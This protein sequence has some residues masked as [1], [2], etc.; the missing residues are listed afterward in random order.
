MFTIS[1]PFFDSSEIYFIYVFLL[2][3]T[4]GVFEASVQRNNC[5]N[6]LDLCLFILCRTSS[7]LQKLIISI[8]EMRFA[9]FLIAILNLLCLKIFIYQFGCFV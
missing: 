2:Q 6:C 5:D 9:L 1:L 4:V 8:P 3:C 7:S